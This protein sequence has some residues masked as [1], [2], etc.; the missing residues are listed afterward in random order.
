MIPLLSPNSINLLVVNLNTKLKVLTSPSDLKNLEQRIQ[1]S[2][3][4]KNI[5]RKV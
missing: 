1:R 4:R 3:D 5:S 2:E